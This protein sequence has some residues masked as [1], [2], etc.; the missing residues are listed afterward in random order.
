[1]AQFDVY[2]NM[3][4]VTCPTFPYLLDIQADILSDLPTRVVV[5][6][7]LS[8]VLNKSIPILTPQF[9][10]NETE[11]RMVTPQLVGVQTHILGSRICSLKDKRGDI[12]AALDLLVTGF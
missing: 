1:M 10:I 2:E 8:S 4:Q 9:A 7:V 12:I 3:D 11:V 5:P 6:L